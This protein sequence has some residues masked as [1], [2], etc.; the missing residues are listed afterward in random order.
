M[1][2]QIL[3][4]SSFLCILYDAKHPQYT[5]AQAAATI[6][7]AELFIPDVVLTE[8]AYLFRRDG[9]VVAVVRFL[10]TLRA[11]RPTLESVNH[12][13]LT[14][15]RD[16]MSTYLD[17]KLNFVDC[18]IMALAECLKI[19]RV[20]TFDRRDFNIFRPKHCDHLDIIP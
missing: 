2:V 14:R 1:A 20:C 11:A 19:T 13:D 16:I 5:L 15:A 18:C 6:N 8:T 10:D 17:A 7:G 12:D 3:I 9:G 4:D